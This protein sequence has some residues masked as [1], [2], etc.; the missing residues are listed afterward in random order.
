MRIVASL[1]LL[2]CY[3]NA[4]GQT[5]YAKADSIARSYPG[6]SLNDLGILAEKLTASLPD[7][8]SKFRA[9]Y[10][11]VC[12]NIAS[13]YE[14]MELNRKKL[15]TLKGDKLAKW[16]KEF[17]RKAIVTLI[18]ERKTVCTGYAWLIRELALRS[19]IECEMIYG[20][21]KTSRSNINGKR[22]LNHTW[23]AVNL[24]GR[25]YLCDAAWSAG[26]ISGET[27]TFQFNYTDSYFLTDPEQFI[28][29]H[30]P[31]DPAWALMERIPPLDF[32]LR[33]ELP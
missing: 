2:T 32:F 30:Y 5:V 24:G 27:R 3:L 17:S 18:G 9:L 26:K 31:V 4:S 19:R 14:M 12:L 23:N 29:D 20:Y 6:H 11:W 10:M 33:A 15:R 13:D 7:D 25:W 16:N 8:A 22:F 28:R 21:G 1:L